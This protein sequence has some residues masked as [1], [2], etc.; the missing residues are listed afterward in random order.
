M[1]RRYLVIICLLMLVVAVS[2]QIVDE[3]MAR[4]TAEN[5]LVGSR[6]ASRAV[7]ANPMKLKL[8]YRVQT[9]M[10]LNCIFLKMRMATTSSLCRAT[11]GHMPYWAMVRVM[12][13]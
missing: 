11:R 7:K 3:Q 8:A 1:E 2:A 12:E 10:C 4:K 9:L 13:Q 5:F 6:N